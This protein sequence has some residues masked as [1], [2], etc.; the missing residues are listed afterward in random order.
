MRHFRDFN[1]SKFEFQNVEFQNSHVL[2]FKTSKL[3]DLTTPK[4]LFFKTSKKF[5]H[6]PPTDT[7]VE[8]EVCG[9]KSSTLKSASNKA[10]HVQIFEPQVH[11][12]PKQSP[13]PRH[14]F[15]LFGN[16][17]WPG[18]EKKRRKSKSKRSE[19]MDKHLEQSGIVKR[20]SINLSL[21]LPS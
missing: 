14:S 3:I 13:S 17:F 12:T 20:R 9:R 16:V 11:S 5:G 1:F 2:F 4:I 7:P 6:S 8:A 19:S 10:L 18:D 15:M 21:R